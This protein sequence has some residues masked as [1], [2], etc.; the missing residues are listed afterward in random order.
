M[1]D[2]AKC[3]DFNC[4]SKEMCYRFTAPASELWQSYGKFNR[5]EDALNCNMFWDN[6]LFCKY[7]HQKNG[8]HKISCPTKKI[9]INL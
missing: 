3:E 9:Q 1:S 2:I 8:V 6:G 5:E 7:C 4:P